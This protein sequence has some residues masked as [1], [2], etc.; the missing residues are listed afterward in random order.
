MVVCPHTGFSPNDI[1]R[2]RLPEKVGVI[3]RAIADVFM[4]IRRREA[5]GKKVTVY[6]SFVQIYNE[7]VWGDTHLREER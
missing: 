5:K 2:G 6:C 7:Q 1:H 3:P 4:A